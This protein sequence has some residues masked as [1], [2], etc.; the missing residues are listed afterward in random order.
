MEKLE[1]KCTGVTRC[2]RQVLLRKMYNKEEPFRNI[3][4]ITII[5]AEYLG[6][7]TLQIFVNDIDIGFIP[8]KEMRCLKDD[9]KP[10]DI[11]CSVSYSPG[12][13]PHYNFYIK[14][15]GTYTARRRRRK[16]E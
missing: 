5:P 2:C 12:G 8:E 7:N 4:R 15:T 13:K 3:S 6:Y 9:F 14:G 10:S 1:I 11:R 16:T